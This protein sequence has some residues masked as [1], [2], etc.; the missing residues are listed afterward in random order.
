[1]TWIVAAINPQAPEP[2]GTPAAVQMANL[3]LLDGLWMKQFLGGSSSRASIANKG[4]AAVSVSSRVD[5]T[6]LNSCFQ[7][8]GDR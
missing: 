3:P 6:A 2:N 7:R 5:L 1:M 4:R 8:L